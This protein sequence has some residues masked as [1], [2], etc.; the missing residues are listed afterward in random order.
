VLPLKT[1]GQE[2]GKWFCDFDGLAAAL[3]LVDGW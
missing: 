3:I 2:G 1:I